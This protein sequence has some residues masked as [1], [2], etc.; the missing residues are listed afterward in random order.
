MIERLR[1]KLKSSSDAARA[2]AWAA[3]SEAERAR[4]QLLDSLERNILR[5]PVSITILGVKLST[6]LISLAISA[7]VTAATALLTRLLT[8]GQRSTRGSLAGQELR[9]DRADYGLFVPEIYGGPPETDAATL[10]VST[11]YVVGDKVVPFGGNGYYYRITVAGTTAASLPT[12]PLVAGQTVTSGSATIRC[13]G[14]TGGGVKAG[15][16]VAW[17][18]EA[19]IVKHVTGGGGGAAA[20]KAGQS[21]RPR[22]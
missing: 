10:A 22:T 16:I 18:P 11:P 2:D 13:E 1:D 7:A 14:R 4:A 20:A 21:R 9:L 15:G 17:A 8:P 3:L 5:D 19:P 12:L 6:I